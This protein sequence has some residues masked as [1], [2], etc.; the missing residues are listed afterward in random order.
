MTGR[1]YPVVK[2]LFDLTAALT[3]LVAFAPVLALVALSLW[4]RSS[5]PVLFR[6]LRVGRG[7]RLFVMYK[8]RTMRVNAPDWRNPDG[9][10]FSANDDPRVTP[11]GRFL[12]STSL[13]E[14][15]Q[16]WNVLLGDM[17]VVGGR[18]DLPS[19]VAAYLPH[20]QERLLVRPGLTSLAIVHG[21][22]KVPLIKRLELD[23][24]YARN[25][26]FLLDLQ[27]IVKTLWIVV[28][29]EGITNEYSRVQQ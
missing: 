4:A 9:T 18:P 23:A 12:R 13:D 26:S 22:N 24:W 27:I 1:Y 7:G 21:R 11:L 5:G 3:S 10:T 15:P 17:S 14:L 8:F 28:R 19:S 2:R 6:Q 20:Q 16:L 25:A 29:R